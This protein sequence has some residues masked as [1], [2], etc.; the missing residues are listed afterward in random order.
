MGVASL[1]RIVGDAALPLDR[2]EFALEALR[3]AGPPA[4]AK[5]TPALIRGLSDPDPVARR[6]ALTLLDQIIG[7]VPA[8]PPG[9]AGGK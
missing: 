8:Q 3:E 6:E 5:T 4:L 1:V 7:E 9:P 2:R